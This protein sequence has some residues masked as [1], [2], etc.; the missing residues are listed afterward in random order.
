MER[1]RVRR[2]LRAVRKGTIEIEQAL[3][4]LSIEPVESLAHAT[5][6]T[7][8]ALRR[9]FPEVIYGPGKTSEQIVEIARALHRAGQSVLVTRVGPELFDHVSRVFTSMSTTPSA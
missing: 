1:E 3:E 4:T 8:R 7:H 6:D 9:G 5:V 2:L